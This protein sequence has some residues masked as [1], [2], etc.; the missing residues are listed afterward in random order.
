M[1]AS[2]CQTQLIPEEFFPSGFGIAMPL[3]SPYKLS[4]MPGK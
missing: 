3:G 1:P 2:G 4:L